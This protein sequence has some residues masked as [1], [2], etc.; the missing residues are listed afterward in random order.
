MDIL[1]NENLTQLGA[2][3][4]IA[5]SVILSVVVPLIRYSS[6]QNNQT[7][8]I[9]EKIIEKSDE[10]NKRQYDDM[11]S[12]T[13]ECQGDFIK[14]LQTVED[15]HKEAVKVISEATTEK[16]E[17]IADRTDAIIE[18]TTVLMQQNE[19]VANDL[20]AIMQAQKTQEAQA[21]ME[22]EI[23]ALK[24]VIN[25]LVSNGNDTRKKSRL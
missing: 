8:V 11:V 13:K 22:N 21:R 1:T 3:L 6:R 17:L 20:N 23:V 5:L 12:R 16:L 10:R 14:S 24:E 15:R 18:V 19:R 4:I 9:L 7:V 2:T 25:G